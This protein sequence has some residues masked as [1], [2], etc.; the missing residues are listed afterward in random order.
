MRGGGQSDGIQKRE[1]DVLR[2]TKERMMADNRKNKEEETELGA[3]VLKKR[4]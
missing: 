3:D 1:I 4:R 2:R